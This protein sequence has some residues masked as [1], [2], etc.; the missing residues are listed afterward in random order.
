MFALCVKVLVPEPAVQKHLLIARKKTHP[1]CNSL[2]CVS[3]RCFV[4]HFFSPSFLS[5]PAV[6]EDPG[7]AVTSG[8]SRESE[9]TGRGEAER[10]SGDQHGL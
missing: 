6:R 5:D 3:G 8:R 9:Q 1:V 4:Q 2:K 10:R 7:E